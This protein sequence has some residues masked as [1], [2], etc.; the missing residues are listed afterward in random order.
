[1]ALT[2]NPEDHVRAEING[3]EMHYI[4]EGPE[5]APAVVLHH[6]LATDLSFWDE[7]AAAL[8]SKW[9]VIRFDARGHGKTAATKAP[10][11]F[12]TLAADTIGLMDHLGVRRAAYVGL[13]M[14]GMVAQFLGLSHPDRFSCLV[15]ASSTSKIPENLRHLWSDRVKVAR[16][17]G[18]ASQVEPC[19][20]RWLAASSRQ[21]A[22]VVERCNR[23]ITAT[24]VEGYGGWCGAIET[25]DMTDKLGGIK[26]PTL[27]VVGQDDPATPVAAS[28]TIQRAIPGANLAVLPGV[29]H[30]LAI[31]DP[32]AFVAAVA[33]F[34]DANRP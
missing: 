14:G 24:P 31:E 8:V 23:L 7:T 21:R 30:M 34:I 29:S 33:P 17:E 3:I 2:E 32:A 13:S 5:A 19:L 4:V 9:R 22:D 18:M 27:V 16:A 28:E 1:M 12:Q 25:L 20:V 10:Y 6:P 15:I 11:D 26:L